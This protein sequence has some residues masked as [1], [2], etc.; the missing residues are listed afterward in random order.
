[1]TNCPAER[2]WEYD[3]S[4]RLEPEKFARAI[5]HLPTDIHSYSNSL[6]GTV[7]KVAGLAALCSSG[8]VLAFKCP[9]N[10]ANR[11]LRRGVRRHSQS[12]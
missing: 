7:K 4:D 5:R 9:P 11:T 10:E 1:M 12:A 3:T 6:D 2:D 8:H